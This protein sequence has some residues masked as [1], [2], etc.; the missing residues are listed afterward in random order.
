MSESVLASG[1]VS[2]VEVK[3]KRYHPALVTLHWLVAVLV[4]VNLYL[5]LFDLRPALLRGRGGFQIPTSTLAVHM[6]TGIAILVLVVLRFIVRS[7][8]KRPADATSGNG[9]LDG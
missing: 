3:P 6:A 7:T 4:L 1:N 9:L 2:A 5:G 8:S